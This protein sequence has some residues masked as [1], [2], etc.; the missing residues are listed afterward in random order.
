MF[1]CIQQELLFD[2]KRAAGKL[3]FRLTKVDPSVKTV[4]AGI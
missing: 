3:N 4:F 2:A 1:C